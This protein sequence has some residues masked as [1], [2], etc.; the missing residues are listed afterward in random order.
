MEEIGNAVKKMDKKNAPGEDG[1]IGEIYEQIFE[2]FPRF[3]TAM[4]DG[5]LRSAFFPKR[6]ERAKLIAIVKPEKENSEEVLKYRPLSILNIV[7]EEL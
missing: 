1:I 5:C 3:I 2:N 4:Y 6:W 7:G